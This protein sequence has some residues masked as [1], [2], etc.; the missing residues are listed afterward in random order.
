[1]WGKTLRFLTRWW[2]P[3]VAALATVAYAIAI[4]GFGLDFRPLQNDEGVTLMV[5]SKLSVSDVLHT[6]IDV[7]HGPP[8]HYLLVHASLD[9]RDNIL[10]LRLPSAVLGILAVAISYGT[11]RELLGRSGGA[12]VSVVVASSPITIHLGQF[13]RGYTAMMAAAFASLWLLLILVRTRHLRWVVPYVLCALMLVA[14]HPFGL[15]ALASEM[16]LLVVLGLGPNLRH[17][18]RWRQE[19]RSYAV[20][21]AAV[22]SGVVVMVLLRQVYAPLQNKYGVGQGSSVIHLGSSEFWNRLGDHASG[23]SHEAGAAIAL[24]AAA[25]AGFIVLLASN[26]RA[27]LVVGIWIALPVALL[28]V[29]TASS[30]DFAPERHLSFL[31][32]GYATAVAAFILE[33]GRRMP[34]KLVPVAVALTA[35]LLYTGLAADYKNLSN[36]NDGLRNASLELGRR[37]TN[38]DSLL[39]TAGKA[40]A[41]EDPRLYGAYAALDAAR[42]SAL[43]RWRQ[44]QRPANCALVRQMQQRPVPRRVWMLVKP[45]DPDAFAASM[46]TTSP[47]TTAQVFSP[48]VLLSAPV[49]RQ[50]PQG[51]I[52]AGARLWRAAVEADPEVHDFR[53]M[54]RVYRHALVLSRLGIC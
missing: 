30:N 40:V 41:A 45:V 25:I 7:R 16:V 52:F 2:P 33:L 47:A 54:S 34:R 20:T 29:F 31:M 51:A 53:H 8:L 28:T 19:W 23:S 21:G 22:V 38:S 4:L 17:P 42:N 35:V 13:A 27:A 26:R 43:G 10:G 50:T 11:G 14:A 36:F 39:T 37:F 49:V 44:I 3:I 12:I 46:L 1:M 32:P 24:G 9:W 5:A 48:Y 18:K 6:A 15:F